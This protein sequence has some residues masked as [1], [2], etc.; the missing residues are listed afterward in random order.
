MLMYHVH[1]YH[2]KLYAATQEKTMQYFKSIFKV[3]EVAVWYYVKDAVCIL[4]P[5]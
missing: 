5:L 1:R 2:D 4:I 3:P